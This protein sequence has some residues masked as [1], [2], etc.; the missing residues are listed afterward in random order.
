MTRRSVLMVAGAVALF[1]LL[2]V[3]VLALGA[4]VGYASE[5]SKSVREPT[6]VWQQ[7]GGEGLPPCPSALPQRRTA[8]ELA[9]SRSSR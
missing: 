2:L 3:G 1:F 4:I 8:D 9:P 5:G 7:C 6:I